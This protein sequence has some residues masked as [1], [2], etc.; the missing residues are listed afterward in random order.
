MRQASDQQHLY[1]SGG[2]E[3]GTPHNGQ[4]GADKRT[5]TAAQEGRTQRQGRGEARAGEGTTHAHRTSIRQKA[6][7]GGSDCESES[8]IGEERQIRTFAQMRM[9]P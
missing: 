9:D 6:Q 4:G 8:A 1:A 7:G 3:G 5:G 2:E